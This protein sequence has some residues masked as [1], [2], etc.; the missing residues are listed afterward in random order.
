[1]NGL[2]LLMG[3]L[4]IPQFGFADIYGE[5]GYGP[6][7]NVIVVPVARA[8]TCAKAD[9]SDDAVKEVQDAISG[10]N[11]SYLD[12]KENDE[13][14]E[15]TMGDPF[16]LLGRISRS[17]AHMNFVETD[18]WVMRS[19]IRVVRSTVTPEKKKKS[20]KIVGWTVCSTLE[21]LKPFEN[22]MS[23]TDQNPLSW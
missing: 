11:L 22:G 10:Q 16:R 19:P 3:F 18:L 4:V 12:E 23:L 17:S 15:V 1:M 14:S 6:T 13:I 5:G 20:E 2:T 9:N 8:T 21:S 7:V